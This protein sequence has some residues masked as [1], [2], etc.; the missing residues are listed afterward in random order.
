[1]FSP[2]KI[3][4]IIKFYH[5]KHGITQASVTSVVDPAE[6]LEDIP[7]WGIWASHKEEG[8]LWLLGDEIILSK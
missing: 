5:P 3:S 1:L 7:H 2:P 6:D 4:T 8:L